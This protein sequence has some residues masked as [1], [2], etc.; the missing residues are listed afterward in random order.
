MNIFDYYTDGQLLMIMANK[1]NTPI[2]HRYETDE[3]IVNKLV[4]IVEANPETWAEFNA[5]LEKAAIEMSNVFA[6]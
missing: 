6:V 4:E 3:D 2:P 1:T 5:D